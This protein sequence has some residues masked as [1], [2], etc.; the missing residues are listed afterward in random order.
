LQGARGSQAASVSARLEGSLPLGAPAPSHQSASGNGK[1]RR[2]RRRALQGS[3]S[4]GSRPSAPTTQGPA[5][6][7]GTGR[8]P[9]SA[10]EKAKQFCHNW[11]MNPEGCSEPCPAGRRHVCMNCE[12]AHRRVNC[13]APA[14][15]GTKGKRSS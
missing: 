3:R 7:A 5:R 4:E 9:V 6:P 13:T 15:G 2:S 10:E 12:G 1:R 11:N 14:K 8:P